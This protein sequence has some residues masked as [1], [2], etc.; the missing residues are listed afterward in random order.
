MSSSRQIPISRSRDLRGEPPAEELSFSYEEHSSGSYYREEDVEDEFHRRLA[1]ANHRRESAGSSNHAS[2]ISNSSVPGAPSNSFW[3]TSSN[4]TSEP[5]FSS[6]NIRSSNS[7]NK[8]SGSLL[9]AALQERTE[10]NS[11]DYQSV[12]SAIESLSGCALGGEQMNS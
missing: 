1:A 10:G 7:Q 9:S 2:N 12:R 11:S 4:E 5:A 3:R 6:V 8:N